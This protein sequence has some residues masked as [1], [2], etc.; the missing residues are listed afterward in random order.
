MLAAFYGDTE[1]KVRHC[2]L[3]EVIC[4]SAMT[5]AQFVF[6]LIVS[7]LVPLTSTGPCEAQVKAS[8][9]PL[10]PAHETT[11]A[12]V[13]RI[14]RRQRWP[15]WLGEGFAEYVGAAGNHFAPGNIICALPKCRLQGCSRSSAIP[16]KSRP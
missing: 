3:L 4:A 16:S 6:L 1:S 10:T 11:H 13:A 14:Y 5:L 12:V 8:P 2:A 9:W 15:V 7:A